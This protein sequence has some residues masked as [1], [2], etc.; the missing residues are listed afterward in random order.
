[1]PTTVFLHRLSKSLTKTLQA[2]YSDDSM[3][4]RGRVQV[5]TVSHGNLLNNPKEVKAYDFCRR[6]DE[7][8]LGMNT[9][10]F[11][12]FLSQIFTNYLNFR[13][14]RAFLPSVQVFFFSFSYAIPSQTFPLHSTVNVLHLYPSK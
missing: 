10:Y 4:C 5:P 11:N 12:C 1:M 7:M 6:R 13:P 2:T 8:S 14:L 9:T 3:N